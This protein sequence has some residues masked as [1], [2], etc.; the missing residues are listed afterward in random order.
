[1]IAPHTAIYDLPL[2]LVALPALPLASFA[3]WIRYALLTPVPY[4]AALSE[5]PWSTAL[6]LMLLGVLLSLYFKHDHERGAAESQSVIF[7]A[8]D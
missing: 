6:P 8:G 7:A 3:K 5:T 2:L 4:W 1:L